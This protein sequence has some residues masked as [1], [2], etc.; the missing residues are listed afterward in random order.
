MSSEDRFEIMVY[1]E[2][3]DGVSTHARKFIESSPDNLQ[4]IAKEV[5]D[6]STAIELLLD[7]HADMVPVSGRWLYDNRGNDFSSALVL[8][9]REPT[10][11]LVGEDKPEYIPK[12]GIIVADCELIRR[13]LLRLRPDLDVRM[14]AEYEIKFEDIFN[15]VNWLEEL[16]VDNEINGYVTNRTL[17]SSLSTR[18]RRHTLGVQRQDDA[19]SRFVPTPLEGYTIL[20]TRSD[21]P[22]SRFSK[23]ID[24][25]ASLSL[26]IEQ[27]ILDSID[28]K[29]HDKIGL[30]VEQRKVRS[31]LQDHGNR[32]RFLDTESQIKEWKSFTNKEE[33]SSTKDSD[34]RIDVIL[35]T[36]SKDG[37][38]TTSIERIFPTDESHTGAQNLILTWEKLIQIAQEKPEEEKRG[39]MKKFM[40]DYIESMLSEGRLSQ[41]RVYSPLFREDNY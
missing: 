9:R 36:L 22:A 6:L 11:V 4:L 39:R 41:E 7:G 21:F 19:R 30:L 23:V 32:G 14:I 35:E 12:N 17:H 28:K 3:G 20:L 10:S 5:P 1:P 25:G 37:M 34:S 31:I 2:N 38:V 16:R 13:Q 29:I 33:E 26:R 24:F 15:Q 27:S 40:D 18:V 8:P